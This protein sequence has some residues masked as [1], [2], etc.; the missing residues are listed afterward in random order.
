MTDI[1]LVRAALDLIDALAAVLKSLKR[2]EEQSVFSETAF[3]SRMQYEVEELR[4][5]QVALTHRLAK[6]E[7][8]KLE[9]YR[10][11]EGA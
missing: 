10:S 9:K 1:E 6:L 2:K 4:T 8:E 3:V 7:Q 5:T 11:T